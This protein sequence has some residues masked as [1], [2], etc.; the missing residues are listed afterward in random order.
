MVK[1]I[2]NKLFSLN[3]FIKEFIPPMQ[4]AAKSTAILCVLNVVTLYL[5]S[6]E[7]QYKENSSSGS[8]S[9]LHLSSSILCRVIGL[10]KTEY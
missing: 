7:Y 8:S 2:Q 3:K 9:F 10:G 5:I 1:P 4:P 6:K